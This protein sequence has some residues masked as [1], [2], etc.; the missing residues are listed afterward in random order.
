ME[1]L[2][3]IYELLPYE[4]SDLSWV[5]FSL[6]KG[7]QTVFCTSFKLYFS[8]FWGFY[9]KVSGACSFFYVSKKRLH[10]TSEYS[11]SIPHSFTWCLLLLHLSNSV[12]K[13]GVTLVLCLICHILCE[14]V[15]NTVIQSYY[16]QSFRGTYAL[17]CLFIALCNRD[18]K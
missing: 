10:S 18:V 17:S 3:R 8:I 11:S 12:L 7:H 15:C 6:L 5:K 2:W 4:G 9:W 13:A 16:F 1:K 14:Y